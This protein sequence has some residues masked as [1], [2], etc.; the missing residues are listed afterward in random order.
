M[1]R[2]GQPT[3]DGFF[4]MQLTGCPPLYRK[5]YDEY[6]TVGQKVKD[7]AALLEKPEGTVKYL[8]YDLRRRLRRIVVSF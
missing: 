5:L 8:L 3:I 2:T 7:I 4:V 1:P 6:Y